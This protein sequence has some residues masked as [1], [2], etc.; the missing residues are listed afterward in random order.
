MNAKQ[1]A[2]LTKHASY[3]STKHMAMMRKLIKEGLSFSAAHKK[4][5]KVIGR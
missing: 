2:Q 4:T 5:Q 3:H 1:K